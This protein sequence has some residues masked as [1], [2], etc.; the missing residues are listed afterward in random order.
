[1]RVEAVVADAKAAA[2][3]FL[4]PDS[5]NEGEMPDLRQK[6]AAAPAISEEEISP[7]LSA[8]KKARTAGSTAPQVSKN[9]TKN[10]V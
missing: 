2:S 5:D 4:K 9:P 1:M 7:F 3:T 10:R 6:A 8:A